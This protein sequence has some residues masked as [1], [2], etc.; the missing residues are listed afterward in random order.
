[1]ISGCLSSVILFCFIIKNQINQ[2]NQL[3]QS[4]DILTPPQSP[5]STAAIKDPAPRVIAGFDL[6]DCQ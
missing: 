5:S 1:M 2:K 4:S 3:H 6:K